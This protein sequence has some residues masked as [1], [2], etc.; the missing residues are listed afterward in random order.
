METPQPLWAAWS[1]VQ[2]HSQWEV[3][4]CLNWVSCIW[5]S[6]YCLSSC[7]WI[8]LERACLHVFCFPPSG[9]DRMDRMNRMPLSYS[10]LN[11]ASPLSLS[12]FVICSK[13]SQSF[14]SF[15]WLSP[16][17]LCLSFFG[18]SALD[19]TRTEERGGITSLDLLVMLC[20]M[21][22]W[23]LLACFAAGVHCWLS[24]CSSGYLGPSLGSCSQFCSICRLAEGT[25]CSSI[26]I[27]VGEA[28]LSWPQDLLL[29]Y[30]LLDLVPLTTTLKAQQVVLCQF[31]SLPPCPL[32]WTK[33]H[34]W[35]ARL[36]W[37]TLSRA[38]LKLRETT[39]TDLPSPPR[40]HL[41]WEGCQVEL[42][43]CQEIAED[44]RTANT[45]LH[46]CLRQWIC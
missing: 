17:C 4:L 41:V 46:Y 26:H 16:P 19:L 11:T 6:T 12:S 22:C 29:G 5:I 28:K 30:S 15:G 25:H 42:L 8:P 2:S 37:E 20:F 9:M 14:W 36:L 35:F 44:K 7:H 34:R 32:T 24:A 10:R 43:G 27:I 40:S 23:T 38:L 3:F 45:L 31:T 13:P 18:I 39:S 33:P 21:R 1:G